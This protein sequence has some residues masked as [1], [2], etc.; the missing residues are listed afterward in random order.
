MRRGQA[1]DRILRYLMAEI[2]EAHVAHMREHGYKVARLFV[3]TSRTVNEAIVEGTPFFAEMLAYD[4]ETGR[5]I[6]CFR[7]RPA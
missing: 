5:S 6:Q 4:E 3:E 7:R 1:R 2:P